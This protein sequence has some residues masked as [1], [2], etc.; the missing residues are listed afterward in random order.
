MSGLRFSKLL[1][2]INGG[3]PLA[4][5]AWDAF[6][7]RLG[8]DPVNYAIRTTGLLSLIFLLLSLTVTPLRRVTGWNTLV[9]YRRSLGLYAFAYACVHLGVYVIFDRAGNLR[10]AVSEIV[11][12]RY[13][14]IGFAGVLLMVPLAVTSTDGMIRRLGPRRWKALHRLAYVAAIAGALHYYLL[15]KSDV[16]QPLAFAGVL[17]ALLLFRAVWHYV[18]LRRAS[19]SVRAAQTVAPSG[20]MAAAKPGAE[21]TSGVAPSRPAPGRR[22]WTGELRVAR[23][24]DET[25]EVR[26]F[27]L[28]P[29][30]GGELPFDYRPGQYLTLR[31]TVDGKSVNRSYTI[32]SS[33][34]RRGYCELTVKR[35]AMGISSGHLHREVRDG[36][37]LAVA[38]PAG[39][40]VFTGAEADGVVL[41]AGGVGL[42]PLM[43]V[44]RYLTDQ[45]WSGGIYLLVV[46]RTEGDIIF[47]DE[48][49]HLRRR[50][51]NLH[52]CITLSRASAA[53]GWTGERGR[54]T[55]E[56][57]TRFV[58]DLA[59]RPVYVCGPDEMMAATLRVLR[60][61][62][63]PDANVK[64]E[65]FAAKTSQL[66]EA[67]AGEPDA[68]PE[69]VRATGPADGDVALPA[70]AGDG[71]TITFAKSGR[72]RFV[73]D[74]VSILEAAEAVGVAIQFECRAGVCGQCKTKLLSGTVRMT[75]EE[76]LGRSEKAAGWI[77]AC[78]AHSDGGDVS[79]QA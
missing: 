59:R 31:L 57:L 70:P 68:A 71:Q 76:A 67:P 21:T 51:P 10:D 5:L 39:N 40:F 34:T 74:G 49:E 30:D 27:R 16:R 75:S 19:T 11:S 1:V 56:L 64:T 41:L 7:G 22:F 37:S 4:L 45:S 14:Q 35:E 58:P 28:A 29:A 50:F 2:A 32:A 79:V 65:A 44:V 20:V 3:V 73:T 18:D 42:T 15:V 48:I 9:A 8:A 38:A 25:P 26:T 54:L 55:T 36:D 63:V 62:G 33:P 6:R 69:T 61:L 43:S 23:T 12:R 53:N 52:V 13:L 66:A 24:F 46:A 60:E 17:A 78:Q 47:R 72:A 77:L